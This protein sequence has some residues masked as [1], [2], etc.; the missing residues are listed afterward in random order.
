MKDLKAA[1]R[2]RSPSQPMRRRSA[3]TELEV[4]ECRKDIV[5]VWVGMA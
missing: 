5:I 1:L 3:R 2:P 4:E